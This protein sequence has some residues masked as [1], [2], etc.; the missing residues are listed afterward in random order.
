MSRPIARDL[1][2]G[3]LA[4]GILFVAAWSAELFS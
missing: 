4:I 3:F 1:I 2:F